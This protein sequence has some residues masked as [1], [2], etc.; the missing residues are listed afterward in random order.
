MGAV[1]AKNTMHGIF[2]IY[3]RKMTCIKM[4]ENTNNTA[5]ET[6]P[7]KDTSNWDIAMC[8]MFLFISCTIPESM[9]HVS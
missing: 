3:V 5:G 2:V 4:R 8:F 7:W 9:C 1:F 6:H